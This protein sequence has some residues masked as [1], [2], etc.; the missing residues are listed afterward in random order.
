VRDARAPVIPG[1][2]RNWHAS[3]KNK[4]FCNLSLQRFA[5]RY[6][7]YDLRRTTNHSLVSI[8]LRDSDVAG[9]DMTM[10]RQLTL[11]V[12]SRIIF[13]V[14]WSLRSVDSVR[15]EMR[16]GENPANRLLAQ[17]CAR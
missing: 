1:P 10:M 16:E 2:H 6:C 14:G 8:E 15:I 13:A 17:R 12:A 9:G 4:G 7:R 11:R 3:L 5:I